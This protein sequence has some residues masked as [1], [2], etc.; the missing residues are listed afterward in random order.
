MTGG[1]GV[2]PSHLNGKHGWNLGAAV[3]SGLWPT[4]TAKDDA[5]KGGKLNYKWVLRLMGYPDGFLEIGKEEYLDLK[6]NKK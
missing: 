2:A 4:P 6:K 1:E 3:N 5:A